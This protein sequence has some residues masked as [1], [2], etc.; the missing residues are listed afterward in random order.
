MLGWFECRRVLLVG[1]RGPVQA[2]CTAKELR[3][4]MGKLGEAFIPEILTFSI[5]AYS[6]L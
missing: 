6:P 5:T 2:A 4:I 3:E 1:R